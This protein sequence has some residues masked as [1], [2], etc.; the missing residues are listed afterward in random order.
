MLAGTEGN[1]TTNGEPQVPHPLFLVL[2]EAVGKERQK[3]I[4]S[5]L[6][7]KSSIYPNQLFQPLRMESAKLICLLQRPLEL[8]LMMT[9]LYPMLILAD[10]GPYPSHVLL[11]SCCLL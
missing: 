7:L 1:P 4:I 3:G 5:P 10:S 8:M 2:E 11:C 6:L 9:T